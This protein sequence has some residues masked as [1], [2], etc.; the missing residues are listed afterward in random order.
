M[1]IDALSRLMDYK[2]R[3]ALL[4][5]LGAWVGLACWMSSAPHVHEVGFVA[6]MSMWILM[7]VATSPLLLDEA[8]ERLF[9][10]SL[11][12]L[13]VVTASAFCLGYLSCWAVAGV[14]LLGPLEQFYAPTAGLLVAAAAVW[15]CSPTRQKCINAC[16]RVPHLRAFGTAAVRDA[17]AAGLATGANCVAACAPLMLLPFVAGSYQLPAMG[18]AAI[19]MILERKML[20]R[21]PR[22][23]LPLFRSLARELH[24]LPAPDQRWL[25][26]EISIAS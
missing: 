4:L 24:C 15:H 22:W 16:H 18:A 14:A 9:R 10:S 19:L 12:R 2:S 7:I 6:L 20:P 17:L 3:P 11:P 21:R 13:R 26:K 1:R 23:Q 8:V 25:P 5:T